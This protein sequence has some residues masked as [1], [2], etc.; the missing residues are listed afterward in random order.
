[1]PVRR[2]PLP[3]LLLL[4]PQP[5]TVTPVRLQPLAQALAEI[6]KRAEPPICVGLYA[7]WGAGKTFMISLLK[8]EFDPD[9][10]VNPRTQRLLQFFEKGYDELESPTEETVT[11]SSLIY[12]MLL[13][14]LLAFIPTIPYGVATFFSIICDAFDPREALHDGWAWCSRLKRSCGKKGKT[15]D[16]SEVSKGDDGYDWLSWGKSLITGFYKRLPQGEEPEE[17]PAKKKDIHKEYIFVDFNAWEYAACV[18]LS[19]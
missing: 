7:R 8:K 11:V 4:S 15:S 18:H 17:K 14:I 6:L 12:G 2:T 13:T 3:L 16:S 19:L 10:R 1:M 5:T 9:V